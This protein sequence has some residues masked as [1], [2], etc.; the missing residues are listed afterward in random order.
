LSIDDHF[1]KFAQAYAMPDATAQTVAH[2]IVDFMLT[3][4]ISD[5]IITDQGTNF[6]SELLQHVYDLLDTYKTRTT[7]YHPEA[8]GNSEVFIRTLKQMIACYIEQPENQQDWDRKLKFLTFAYNSATHTTTGFS[9]FEALM[10]REQKIP[11]DLFDEEIIIELPFNNV[12]YVAQ[13]KNN[14]TNVNKLI[15]LIETNRSF[16]MNKAKIRHDRNVVGCNFKKG[17]KVWKLIESRKKGITSSIAAKQD[18]PY[19]IIEILNNGQDYIIKQDNKRSRPK[20]IN[21]SKLRICRTRINESKSNNQTTI[22]INDTTDNNISQTNNNPNIK[23]EKIEN[24]AKRKKG[25][26]KKQQI[27]SNENINEIVEN[28]L[29]QENNTRNTNFINKYK[30]RSRKE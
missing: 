18:G 30:L 17:D 3:Y 20:T 2:F 1:T 24:I 27:V 12:E 4:G 15:E 29:N 14:F 9:P 25:R 23:E 8:D 7:P 28:I 13:L 22:T 21:R 16:Q 19:T 10:G 11:S 26:L 5:Q 6:Q